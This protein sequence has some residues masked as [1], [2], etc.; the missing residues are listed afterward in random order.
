MMDQFDSLEAGHDFMTT[1]P[2][3]PC[4]VNQLMIMARGR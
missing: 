1:S 4:G 2:K 3:L